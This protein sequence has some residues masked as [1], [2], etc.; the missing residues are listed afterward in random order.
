MKASLKPL[1]HPKVVEITKI[2]YRDVIDGPVVRKDRV[3][4]RGAVAVRSAGQP[5]AATIHR[6]ARPKP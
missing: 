6:A 4:M 3:R 2:G 5:P 1:V